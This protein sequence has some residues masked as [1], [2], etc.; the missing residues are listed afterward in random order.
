MTLVDPTGG[1]GY[2]FGAVL[3]STHMTTLANQQ[4]DAVDGVGGGSYAGNISW[5]GAHDIS[6]SMALN[7]PVTFNSSGRVGWRLN[8]LVNADAD[9]IADYDE[10]R[11]TVAPTVNRTYTLRHTGTVPTTGNRIR[12]IMTITSVTADAIFEREDTTELARIVGSG[13]GGSVEFTYHS[14]GNGWYCSDASG[15]GNVTIHT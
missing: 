6:G 12:A 7:C 13:N 1:T 8:T 14:G 9:M 11:F 15:D 10:Y 2:A 4:P 5:S 3:S